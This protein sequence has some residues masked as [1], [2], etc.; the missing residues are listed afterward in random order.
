M[1]KSK[2]IQLLIEYCQ[3]RDLF[4][5]LLAAL[6]RTRPDQYAQQFTVRA[7]VELPKHERDPRQIF[8][9]YAHQDADLAHQLA[10]DLRIHN[11]QVWIA[12]DSIRP[13]ENGLKRLTVG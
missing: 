2:K 9:S 10:N 3:Q 13:G 8:I 4:P 7:A 12:P 1:S 5:N 11:W 6:Q